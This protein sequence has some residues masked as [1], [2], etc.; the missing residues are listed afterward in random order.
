MPELK[1]KLMTVE[2]LNL[3]KYWYTYKELTEII[4]LP[5]RSLTRYVNGYVLPSI[6]RA[7]A[8]NRTLQKIINLESTIKGRIIFDSNRSFRYNRAPFS[9][10]T[11]LLE[12]SVQHIVN[13]FAGVSI[14]KVIS[15]M[16][17]ALP[18]GTLVAHRM[19]VM[20]AIAAS[21]KVPGVNQ[22]IEESYSTS[23]ADRVRSLYIPSEIIRRG[24]RFL[25]V[26]DIMASGER[27]MCA[28]SIIKMIQSVGARV[29]GFFTLVSIGQEWKA[30]VQKYSECEKIESIIQVD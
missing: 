27:E 2:L 20:L 7:R 10:D 17:E 24:D 21:Y 29:S 18:L 14:N 28:T 8:I 1:Y 5:E 23:S 25:I 13:V 11:L 9:C 15:T 12:R 16:S 22:F 4:G 30:S 6:D 3:A 26:Y 19:G